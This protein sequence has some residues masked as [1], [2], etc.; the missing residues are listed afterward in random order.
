MWSRAIAFRSRR[1]TSSRRS[2]SGRSRRSSRPTSISSASRGSY[3]ARQ[4]EQRARAGWR[5]LPRAGPHGRLHGRESRC[6]VPAAAGAHGVRA[7]EQRVRSRVLHG[8][9]ARLD[10]LQRRRQLRRASVRRARSSMAS[11]RCSARRS[12]RRARRART[13]SACAI[14]SGSEASGG[15]RKGRVGHSAATGRDEL[16]HRAAVRH[17]GRAATRSAILRASFT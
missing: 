1:G 12:S 8:R 13:G 2:R 5:V 15:I 17:H 9:A 7:G 4:R 11:G 14:R 16:S 6:G 10:R 3:R